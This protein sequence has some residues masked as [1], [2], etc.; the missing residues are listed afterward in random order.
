MLMNAPPARLYCL[1]ARNAR[2][3]V[4]FRRGPSRCVLLIRWNLAN[5]TFQ[6]GQWLKGRIYERRSDLSPSGEKLIYFAAN[7]K[8]PLYSWTALSK[9]PWLTAIAFWPKGDCW[10]GGGIFESVNINS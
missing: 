3:G 6:T 9:P 5:D 7:H 10:N 2:M 8:P 4:I 1:L